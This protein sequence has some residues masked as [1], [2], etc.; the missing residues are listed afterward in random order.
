MR[1]TLAGGIDPEV[2]GSGYGVSV[3]VI[4]LDVI[5]TQLKHHKTICKVIAHNKPSQRMLSAL[6]FTLEGIAR[7][8]EFD[9][10]SNEYIDAQYFGLLATEYP[11]H[12]VKRRL[13]KFI[14]EAE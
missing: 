4:A 5:F 6:G 1:C 3:A 7:A 9:Y 12:F 11:N 2:M 8:H 10:R 13:R 14:Y